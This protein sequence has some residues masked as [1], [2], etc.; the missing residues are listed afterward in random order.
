MC[1]N[2]SKNFNHESK[3]RLLDPSRVH[4]QGWAGKRIHQ[5]PK[6]PRKGK[7]SKEI[8]MTRNLFIQQTQAPTTEP[9]K[10]TD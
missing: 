2:T 1:G 9:G 8:V 5:G 3:I 7:D 10:T 6:E 4:T